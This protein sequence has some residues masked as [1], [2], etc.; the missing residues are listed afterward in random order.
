MRDRNAGHAP[1]LSAPRLESG[2]HRC[3]IGAENIREISALLHQ[4]R[5]QSQP[6]DRRANAVESVGGDSKA[7]ERIVL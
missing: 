7:R 5:R 3:Q 4:Y 1:A 2:K 6:R